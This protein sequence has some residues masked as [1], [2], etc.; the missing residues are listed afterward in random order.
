MLEILKKRRAIRDYIDKDVEDE[1]LAILLEAA[2]LAPN[3]RLREPWS[4]YV[5]KGEAKKRYEQLAEEYLNERFPTKPHLVESSLK[6]VKTTP[7]HIVV[8]SD[9]VPDDEDATKDNEFAVCCA[10]HSMWL[11]AEELGLG[12]VW[13]TRGV[14]LVHDDR[15]HEFVGSPE[16]KKVIGNIFVGYPDEESLNKLKPS[17]RTSYTEKTTWL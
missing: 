2:T 13:R 11:A 16:N 5:I 15:L 10:I 1:K 6:V 17:K 12:F 4:F 8:T 3:D 14:G 7:V 9:I